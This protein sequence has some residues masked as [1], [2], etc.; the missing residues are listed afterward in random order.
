MPPTLK[1]KLSQGQFAIGTWVTFADPACMEILSAAGF[2]FLLID[3][4]HALIGPETLRD[5]LIAGKDSPA[6]L[7]VRV[8][9]N[10]PVRIK[11]VLD[12]GA[13]GIMAPMVNSADEARLAVAACKYPPEGIRSVGAWRPSRYY[14]DGDDY[15]R[16]ANAETTVIV[17]IEHRRAVE[18]LDEILKVPGIDAFF[19]GPADLSASLNHLADSGH[20]DV[21]ATIERI[22][23]ACRSAG[24][25]F[26]MDGDDPKR[27]AGLGARLF[28]AGIDTWFLANGA[29]TA[30]A[31]VRAA[32][33]L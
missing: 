31:E 27:L 16:R 18:A 15:V 28:T 25:A 9:W 7:I 5:L 21:Q 3:A 30:A 10:D 12:L 29:M 8:P 13:D 22:F 24:V 4:E 19:I 23:A 2:D 26:G 20:P 33:G 17:Q 6:S 1:R 11:I 32:L 14:L